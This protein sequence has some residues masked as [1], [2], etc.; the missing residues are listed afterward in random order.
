M[1]NDP[2]FTTPRF[3]CGLDLDEIIRGASL[4]TEGSQ[5]IWEL[6]QELRWRRQEQAR[7]EE[8]LVAYRPPPSYREYL[9]SAEWSERRDAAIAAAGYRCQVC[10]T[11]DRLHVHHRT[12]ERLSDEEP[13]DLTVLCEGC[14]EAFHRTRR[15]RAAV[16]VY[17]SEE[18]TAT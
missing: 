5:I 16:A 18:A 10:N 4:S 15:L 13:G 14:H 17:D 9:Q 2:I 8:L 1:A 11:P 6:A 12:Y 7:L 3:I